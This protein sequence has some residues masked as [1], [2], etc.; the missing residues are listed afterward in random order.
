ML[1]MFYN[2]DQKVSGLSL[3]NTFSI[4]VPQENQVC[5]E[6]PELMALLYVNLSNFRLLFLYQYNIIVFNPPTL[7]FAT[8][9]LCLSFL[10]SPRKGGSDWHQRKPGRC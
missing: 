6:C 8:F 7:T 2:G 10:G 4:R 1:M 3:T 5:Q 9:E